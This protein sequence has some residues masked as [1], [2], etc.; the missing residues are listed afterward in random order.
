MVLLGGQD[1]WFKSST[2][3]D[4]VPLWLSGDYVPLPLSL[5]KVKGRARHSMELRP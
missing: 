4:Q 1:G 3:L 2:F 5:D